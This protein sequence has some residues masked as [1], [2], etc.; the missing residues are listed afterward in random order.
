MNKTF[1]MCMRV[2]LCVFVCK[3]GRGC[4]CLRVCLRV[5]LSVCVCARVCVCVCVN[6]FRERG[7]QRRTQKFSCDD[8]HET[9]LIL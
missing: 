9:T 3:G 2:Y 1:F 6:M 8:N 7:R 5:S 4:V